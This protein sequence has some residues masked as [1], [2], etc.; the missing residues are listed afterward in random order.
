MSITAEN[1]CNMA[2]GHLK[3]GKEISDLSDDG[4]RSAEASACRLYYDTC[5]QIVMSDFKWPFATSQVALALV[6]E[7]PFPV[8]TTDD[9]G[10]ETSWSEWA[11]SY[12]YPADASSIVRLLSGVRNE[13]RSDRIPYRIMRDADGKLILT[14]LED[15]YC[16]FIV[17]EDTEDRF[18]AGFAMALSLKL[19]I[20]IAPRLTGGDPFKLR[21]ACIKLYQVE[22][23][24]AQ[25]SALNEEQ[26]EEDPEAESIRARY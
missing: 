5:R 19:A 15:A 23:S 20:Y 7:D 13:S 21:D 22:L 18:D 6:E 3:I 10:N 14:D 8:V 4:D 17:N 11:F 25:A 16:E 12:R 9:D 26:M 24:S 1:I 2:L